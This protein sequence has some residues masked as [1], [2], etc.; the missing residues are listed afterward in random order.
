L[1][2]PLDE[3]LRVDEERRALA[4]LDRGNARFHGIA[5][6]H[7]CGTKE[8]LGDAHASPEAKR[9]DPPA[10]TL[11]Q[12]NQHGSQSNRSRALTA[13]DPLARFGRRFGVIVRNADQ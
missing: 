10:S 3:V 4:D 9:L 2:A 12:L 8:R 11:D 5:S 13:R 1:P 6:L 7:E